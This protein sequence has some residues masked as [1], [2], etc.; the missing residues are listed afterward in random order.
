MDH[1]EVVVYWKEFKIPECKKRDI[2]IELNTDLVVTISGPRRAGKTYLCFQLIQELKRNGT[3]EKNIMYVNFED[4]RMLNASVDDLNQ[5]FQTYVEIYEPDRSQPIFLFFDEIHNISGWDNWVRRIADSKPNV[6][7][8]LTGSSS[9]LLSREIST[10]LRGRAVNFE[11]YPLSFKEYLEWKDIRYDIKTIDKSEKNKKIESFFSEYL[12]SGGYPK[13]V[14]GDPLKDKML[15]SYYDVMLLRDIIERYNI[16]DSKQLKT[17]ASLLFD[18]VSS[19]FSYNKIKNR[20]ESLGFKASKNTIIEYINYFEE[21]YLFFQN[22]K[23]EY[24][25]HKQLGSIKKIYCIDN[26]LINANSFKFSE[27][28]GKLLENLVYLELRRRGREIFYFRENNECDFIIKEKD[29]LITAIQ[30]TD[31]LTVENTAR[32]FDGLRECAR[33]YGITQGFIL[34]NNNYIQDLG[35]KTYNAPKED[36][37]IKVMPAWYFLLC[38]DLI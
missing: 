4:E 5:I 28:N 36:I 19:E 6:K 3:N 37:R 21:A 29:K 25:T 2:V 32:E 14:L 18:S 17:V 34:T 1:K 30:V 33:K 24:S 27:N 8:V 12:K 31:K 10:K 13:I 20:L 7:I 38:N 22:L 11:I 9:K 23:Y 15:Q 26:G 35:S 16:R